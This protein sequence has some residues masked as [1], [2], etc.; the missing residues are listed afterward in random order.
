VQEV[1][2]RAVLDSIVEVANT[3]SQN[4]ADRHMRQTHA[5]ARTKRKQQDRCERREHRETDEEFATMLSDPEHCAVIQ[6]KPKIKEI[7][8]KSDPPRMMRNKERRIT[9]N[10]LAL[11]HNGISSDRGK[12]PCLGPEIKCEPTK[13]HSAKRGPRCKRTPRWSV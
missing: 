12:R 8:G 9:K 2:H 1:S 11:E 7:R 6:H 3:S 5:H 13:K 10:A 4:A